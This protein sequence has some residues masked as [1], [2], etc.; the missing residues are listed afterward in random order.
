MVK[1]KEAT[2]TLPKTDRYPEVLKDVE[3]MVAESGLSSSNGSFGKSTVVQ[4]VGAEEGQDT[5]NLQG[6]RKIQLSYSIKGDID[7]V[8][9][10]ID[11]LEKYDRIAEL[12]SFSHSGETCS[13]VFSFYDSGEGGKEEYDFN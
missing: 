8:L 4:V 11:K 1:Y 7:K 2:V 12:N 10:F 6:M 5:S 13:I 9:T 3:K